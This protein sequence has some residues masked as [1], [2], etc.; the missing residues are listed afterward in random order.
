[1]FTSTSTVTRYHPSWSPTLRHSSCLARV[2]L[3]PSPGKSKQASVFCEAS[4]GW[5][6]SFG[7]I[8][9]I[10]A[11]LLKVLDQAFTRISEGFYKSFLNSAF[12]K[13]LKGFGSLAKRVRSKVTSGIIR[14][15]YLYSTQNLL[16]KSILQVRIP[17]KFRT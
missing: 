2:P 9:F 3:S 1:M 13:L 7:F 12:S 15:K 4:S 5:L 6:N 11:C 16:P 17:P 8:R 10:T 14:F